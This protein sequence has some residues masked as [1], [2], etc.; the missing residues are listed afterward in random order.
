[1]RIKK[2]KKKSFKTKLFYIF[3][4]LF[5]LLC[6]GLIFNNKIKYFFMDQQTNAFTKKINNVTAQEIKENQTKP[7][8]FDFENVQSISDS[9][10]ASALWG[11]LTNNNS[12]EA[13]HTVGFVAV[14]SVGINLPIFEGVSNENLLFGAGTLKP[15]Q[16]MGKNNYALASHKTLNDSL[17]FSPLQYVDLGEY[18]YTSNQEKIFQYQITD[19]ERIFPTQSEVIEDVKDK[20]LITLITCNDIHAI[21]RLVVIGEYKQSWNIKN[22]PSEVLEA[23]NVSTK[24]L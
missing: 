14:P 12:P 15:N 21:K 17:L 24:T 9:L 16:Q 7:A 20:T 19:I 11:N 3:I 6:L 8:S 22:A 4:S 10:V 1:M 18:I 23:F 5:A 13:F 2:K